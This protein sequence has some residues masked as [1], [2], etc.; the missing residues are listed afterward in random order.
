MCCQ[1]VGPDVLLYRK[2][3]VAF[4]ASV[5]TDA[6]DLDLSNGTLAI[7]KTLVSGGTPRHYLPIAY[8]A[9]VCHSYAGEVVCGM[10]MSL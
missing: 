5:R 1:G 2:H 3:F 10:D 7:L 8:P 6:L 9:H 4:R